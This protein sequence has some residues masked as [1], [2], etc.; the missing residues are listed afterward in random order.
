M[1]A[2]TE[3]PRGVESNDDPKGHVCNAAALGHGGLLMF[4]GLKGKK[5]SPAISDPVATDL[6]TARRRGAEIQLTEEFVRPHTHSCAAAA[7]CF[8]LGM[9]KF[10]LDAAAIESSPLSQWS[11]TTSTMAQLSH[12]SPY[13]LPP[14]LT[15]VRGSPTASRPVRSSRRHDGL[16]T[17]PPVQRC[18]DPFGLYSNDGG[19]AAIYLKIKSGRLPH[20][21]RFDAAHGRVEQCECCAVRR[22]APL[23]NLYGLCC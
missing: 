23:R 18:P 5:A 21:F 6:R 7:I 9:L 12:P 15:P 1:R 19:D 2:R 22:E 20:F 3:N 16:T 11:R 4:N 8:W 13:R 14:P 17:S 10:S